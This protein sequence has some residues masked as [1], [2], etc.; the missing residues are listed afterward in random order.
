MR[1]RLPRL[2]ALLLIV[3][4]VVLLALAG[5]VLGAIALIAPS[6]FSAK[7]T[8]TMAFKATLDGRL[9]NI[10]GTSDLPDGAI[11]SWVVAH[12][13][14][15]KDINGPGPHDPSV[16]DL[17]SGAAV[18]NDGHFHAESDLRA[19]PPGNV[20]ITIQFI[21]WVGQPPAIVA[22]FGEAGERL[23]GPDVHPD[24]G[25]ERELMVWSE[26]VLP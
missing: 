18:L 4:A 22:R 1:F 2:P 10:D 6:T 26:L 21:P 5:L 23:D 16:P 19:W 20:E 11:L 9:L 14:T 15:T 17:K 12:E 7:T 3:G 8:A 24:S 13:L 25:D